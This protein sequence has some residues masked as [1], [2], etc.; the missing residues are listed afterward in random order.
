MT[1]FIHPGKSPA[2]IV[3]RYSFLSGNVMFVMISDPC[4]VNSELY[5]TGLKL[6]STF[7]RCISCNAA[8]RRWAVNK[9]GCYTNKL[10][11]QCGQVSK[12][13]ENIWNTNGDNTST[14]NCMK[15]PFTHS[16]AKH[17]ALY[18]T[19]SLNYSRNSLSYCRYVQDRH[20]KLP[21]QASIVLFQLCRFH[22]SM[23]TLFENF[24]NKYVLFSD[25]LTMKKNPP[26][27]LEMWGNIQW[28]IV[29]IQKIRTFS[30]MAVK[31]S[32]LAKNAYT[33]SWLKRYGVPLKFWKA[34]VQW[35][36]HL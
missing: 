21:R 8:C 19:G 10:S 1:S 17:P 2:A 16:Y 29:T 30:N 7:K 13:P 3:R 27:F 33:L 15:T 14:S 20:A 4:S 5:P 12:T 9:Y 35:G 11:V 34:D 22:Y 23:L 24:L 25:H 36:V 31:T 28:H 26:W 6:P 32:N 18:S